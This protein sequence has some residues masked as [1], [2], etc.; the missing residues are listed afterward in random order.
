MRFY[1]IAIALKAALL[2]NQTLRFISVL[3]LATA[4][5]C[6]LMAWRP[7]QAFAA[8]EDAAVSQPTAYTQSISEHYNFHFGADKPFLPSS[9]TTETGGF[10]S[11]RSFP[12][13]AYCGHC[14]QEAHA[15]W[16]QSVHANSFRM[17][18]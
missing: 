17:C 15:E 7:E 5:S 10:I 18:L 13:A 3:M 2:L 9:A 6:G 12:T 8:N 1:R 14:H 4:V 11:P 16:R